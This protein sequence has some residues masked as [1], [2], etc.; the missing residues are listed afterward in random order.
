MSKDVDSANLQKRLEELCDLLQQRELFNIVQSVIQLVDEESIS[1]CQDYKKGNVRYKENAFHAKAHKT[2]NGYEFEAAIVVSLNEAVFDF[3]FSSVL[4][5]VD[6]EK[7]N[8]LEEN[9][10]DL[11]HSIIFEEIK[12]EKIE[13]IRGLL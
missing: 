12:K 1:I 5:N 6:L 3:Y 2:E 8:K 10:P 11:L 4:I 9:L 7:V 13:K